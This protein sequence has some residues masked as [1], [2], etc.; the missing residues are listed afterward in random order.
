MAKRQA[1]DT[2]PEIYVSTDVEADGPIPGPHSMLSFAS[3]AMLADKTVLG[4]FSANLETLPGAAGHPVQMQWWQTQPEAW[5]ACRRDL[6]RPEDAVVRY[7]E[8]VEA[9]PGKPVFVAFPA[10]FD[11]TWMFW[12]MMR[13]AGRSPFGW[14][15]LDVKTLGFALTG[16]PYRKTVKAAFPAGWMDPLPHTHVALDDAMEQGALFCN[17]LATLREREAELAALTAEEAANA[18]VP[19]PPPT[20]S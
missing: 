2:R 19:S 18:S 7:V 20:S 4:T 8:W 11:F 1:P 14:A 5:S 13:F 17:M 16:R 9:L 12:Y 3:V 6:Q 15:A 10:G